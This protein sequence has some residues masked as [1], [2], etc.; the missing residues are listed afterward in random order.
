MLVTPLSAEA[1]RQHCSIFPRTESWRIPTEKFPLSP[2]ATA[3]P[4]TSHRLSPVRR[5]RGRGE[6]ARPP[7]APSPFNSGRYCPRRAGKEGIPPR[8][9]RRH[10]LLSPHRGSVTSAGPRLCASVHP[11]SPAAGAPAP[12]RRASGRGKGRR[13]MWQEGTPGLLPPRPPARCGSLSGSERGLARR[14]SPVAPRPSW[15]PGEG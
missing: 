11:S 2:A 1:E 5:L 10:L 14:P 7:A 9:R 3:A 12:P 15:K 13:T 4:S 6:R 8:H